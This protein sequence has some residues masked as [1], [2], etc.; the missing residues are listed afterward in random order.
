[1]K[2]TESDISVFSR[3]VGAENQ[4]IQWIV[5]FENTFD[6]KPN[7]QDFKQQILDALKLWNNTNGGMMARLIGEF[8]KLYANQRTQ[9]DI[10]NEQKLAKI[11]AWV[12][13]IPTTE[14]WQ[15]SADYLADQL[16]K[17]LNGESKT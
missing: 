4:T 13:R 16:N 1:M 3:L 2:I 15:Y 14:N 9:T 5:K 8:H 6:S 12:D 17:I 11:Q 10:D 7:A